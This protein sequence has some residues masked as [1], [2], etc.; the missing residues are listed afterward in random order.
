[1][2]SGYLGLIGKIGQFYSNGSFASGYLARKP[3]FKGHGIPKKGF[4]S[5]L[6]L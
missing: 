2:K 4:I 6:C 1:M 5:G 3:V